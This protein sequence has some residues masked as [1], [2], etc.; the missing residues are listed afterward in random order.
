MIGTLS[1]SAAEIIAGSISK[2]CKLN[3]PT[4]PLPSFSLNNS[5]KFLYISFT[6]L[7]LPICYE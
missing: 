5:I 4:A 3:A 2:Q 1:S 7:V 6:P